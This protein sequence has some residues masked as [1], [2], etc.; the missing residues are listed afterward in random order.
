M[1]LYHLKD[2]F[3]VR[4]SL[5]QC[6]VSDFAHYTSFDCHGEPSYILSRHCTNEYYGANGPCCKVDD[7]I[8][9]LV[10]DRP[11][12]FKHIKFI[13]HSDDDEYWRADQVL[14]WLSNVDNSGYYNNNRFIIITNK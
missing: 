1:Y 5:R 14:R 9:Y 7:A 12:L 4:F 13:L 8:N 2:T 11:A 6:K 10:N 3:A